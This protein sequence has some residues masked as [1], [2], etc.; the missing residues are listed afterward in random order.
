MEASQEGHVSIVHYLIQKGAS[1]HGTTNTG[2]SALTYACANGHKV[3]VE[4]LLECGA[5]LVGVVCDWWF[6]GG[7]CIE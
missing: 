5:D 2:D 6:K 3:I 4:I 7:E 1:I